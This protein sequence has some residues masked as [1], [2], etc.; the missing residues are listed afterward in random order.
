MDTVFNLQIDKKNPPTS[1]GYM[2]PKNTQS[3]YFRIIDNDYIVDYDDF[4][5]LRLVVE[6]DTGEIEVATINKTVT[7]QSEQVIEYKIPDKY[8]QKV[9]RAVIEP[10]VKMVNK[11]VILSKFVIVFYDKYSAE[12]DG[13]LTATS[14][15]N[16][17]LNNFWNKIKYD[18]L[19]EPNGVIKLDNNGDIPIE[20]FPD[21]FKSHIND[22]I[23]DTEKRKFYDRNGKEISIHGLEFDDKWR[24]CYYDNDDDEWYVVNQ[25]HGGKFGYPNKSSEWN[26][27]GGVWGTPT[28]N[29]GLFT[30]DTDKFIDGGTFDD[31]L[32]GE[33]DANFIDAGVITGDNIFGGTFK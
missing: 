20:F 18:Q 23:V 10:R 19:N 31:S 26:I 16:N 15:F 32:S 12:M 22:K 6:F 33:V 8:L 25:V 17:M 3:L 28:I 9:N 24:L 14:S 4:N 5:E 11:T 7:H 30:Q 27:H 1:F 29:A 13:I 2:I 21:I